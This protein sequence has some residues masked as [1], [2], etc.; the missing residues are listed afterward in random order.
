M[1]VPSNA[2]ALPHLAPHDTLLLCVDL[3]PAFLQAIP[4]GEQVKN[5]C[6]F[7]L[8]VGNKLALP[9]VF[10]QQARNTSGW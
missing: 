3:Q 5:R 7:A 8:A 1:T 10:T 4:G 9:I 2:P 6:A